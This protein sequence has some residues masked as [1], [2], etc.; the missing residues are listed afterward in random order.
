MLDNS[1][2]SPPGQVQGNLSPA[3]GCSAD[4]DRTDGGSLGAGYYSVF[5]GEEEGTFRSQRPAAV[6]AVTGANYF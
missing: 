3:A 4:K 6:K 2:S 5:K 1:D